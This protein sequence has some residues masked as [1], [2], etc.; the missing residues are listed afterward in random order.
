MSMV[1]KLDMSSP[2][3]TDE[4]E[5]DNVGDNAEKATRE[6]LENLLEASE[7]GSPQPMYEAI[8][9]LKGKNGCSGSQDVVGWIPDPSVSYRRLAADPPPT[10]SKREN[11]NLGLSRD[12]TMGLGYVKKEKPKEYFFKHFDEWEHYIDHYRREHAHTYSVQP[13]VWDHMQIRDNKMMYK[14][15]N[16]GSSEQS[17]GEEMGTAETLRSVSERLQKEALLP[18]AQH[19]STIDKLYGMASNDASLSSIFQL[20]YNPY[21]SKYK[22]APPKSA[23]STT[24][25]GSLPATSG[26]GMINGELENTELTTEGSATRN[27]SRENSAKESFSSRSSRTVNLSPTKIS[28]ISGA[29]KQKPTS[30]DFRGNKAFQKNPAASMTGS[31]IAL[32]ITGRSQ[33]DI[34]LHTSNIKTLEALT[35]MASKQDQ[36]AASAPWGNVSSRAHRLHPEM[37]FDSSG[38]AY[39]SLA[40]RYDP[41]RK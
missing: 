15:L 36:R 10:N 16:K 30:G 5:I 2:P 27:R 24:L 29:T 20:G 12:L 11:S 6:L 17:R 9:K 3:E 13:Y 41:I 39:V 19:Q 28:F 23:A 22:L 40:T 14:R 25:P 8:H 33:S 37:W 7:E 21:N 26:Q 31:Q 18:Q 38:R 32:N 35:Q 1:E 34:L 4:E